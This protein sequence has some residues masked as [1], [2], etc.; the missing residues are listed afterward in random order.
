MNYKI[1][2]VVI[3]PHPFFLL[4][5]AFYLIFHK[6]STFF[7][8]RMVSEHFLL[9]LLTHSID[10]FHKKSRAHWWQQS[11]CE[12]FVGMIMKYSLRSSYSCSKWIISMEQHFRSRASG[13]FFISTYY[14]ATT[15]A[16]TVAKKWSS[17]WKV[18]FIR[19]NL[20][21]ECRH[22]L[23]VQHNIFFFSELKMSVVCMAGSSYSNRFI[24]KTLIE[25]RCFEP[26]K[27]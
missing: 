19:H 16:P 17:G 10:V 3:H 5:D 25:L 13:F 21:S 2:I 1:L 4:D 22:T 26:A 9:N 15:T 23:H 8:F 14:A 27:A 11:E 12:F 24:V 20:P 6:N 7:P 18:R